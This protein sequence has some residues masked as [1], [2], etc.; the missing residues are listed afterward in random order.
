MSEETPFQELILRVRARDREAA[1]ELW[2]R[3]E[4]AV[5]RAVR[6]HARDDLLGP[7][8]SADDLCQSVF[9]TL[10]E[11]LAQGEFALDSPEQLAALLRKIARNKVLA[12]ARKQRAARRDSRRVALAEKD[13]FV[14]RDP[15][16]SQ[17]AVTR[18]ILQRAHQLLSPEERVLLELRGAG[19][20]WDVIAAQVGGEPVNLRQRLSRA[21][22]HV[23]EQ[24][25]SSESSDE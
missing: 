21:L 16:P 18:E 9:K 14:A 4:R 3:Y 5:Q 25:V 8:L 1:Q 12:Q 10:Y 2:R 17:Q 15:S 23:R 24:L 6:F 19:L 13:A 11:R 7:M 22:A 20:E